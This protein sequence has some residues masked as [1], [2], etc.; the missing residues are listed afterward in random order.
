MRRFCSMTGFLVAWICAGLI[1]CTSAPRDD[2]RGAATSANAPAPLPIS[3]NAAPRNAYVLLS[4]GGT[5]L[6]NNYSQYLQAR[7]IADFFER[8]CANEPTWVFFGAGNRE[9]AAPVLGDTLRE[10]KRDGVIVQSWLPGTLK[11][12]RPATRDSFLRALREE[13]LPTVKS[14]GTLY[15]FVGDHGELIG[16]NDKRE[17]AITLWQLKRGR[18]RGGW[19]TDDR[20]VLGVAELRQILADGIGRGRVVFC[21]TQCHGGGFHQLGVVREQKPLRS[22]FS[23]P[24]AGAVAQI[25]TP[26][27]RAA[28]FTATD[29]QSVAAGCDPDPDP[30]RWAGYERFMPESLLGMDLMN[31]RPK[32]SPAASFA[33]AHEAA[34][35]V[36]QTVD[37]PRAT[38]EHYLA[39]W[40]RLIETQ[41]TN[42]LTIT[43]RTQEAV[44]AFQRAV[45][46]GVVDAADDALRTRRDQFGR[47]TQRLAEQIP[48]A[49][50]LLL[51]GTQ[52]ELE[53]AL[54]ERGGGRGGP[55]DA[56]RASMTELRR[57]WSDTLRPAWKAAVERGAV[58]GLRGAA[59]DFEKQL[60]STE[61]GGRDL[62]LPRGGN[63]T[64]L[65]NEAYWASGYDNPAT[66]NRA[67]AEAIMQWAAERRARIVAWGRMAADAQ[68]RAAAEK[69]GP[70]PTLAAEAPRSLSRRTAAER[71]LF[72]RRV[73]AA[74]QFLLAMDVQPA[75]AE[76]R[77]LIEL[78]HT[79]V[80][81]ARVSQP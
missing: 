10:M 30:D 55:R 3:T 22:W 81:P 67:E 8:E 13:I 18:R 38:S 11:N 65:S 15:L 61:A 35:M 79:P 48:D 40:A 78:E 54:R 77:Q 28:G 58:P 56:R 27:L 21:M 25:A 37:K 6:T 57:V 4:G 46:R 41:L 73:L 2:Q 39:G 36:D 12:N 63:S 59:L 29:Q 76:L 17:S 20:E 33:L 44:A 34:T 9:G 1:G 43:P 51:T 53:A 7:A 52:K 42:T 32:F 49:R 70:G 14:G 31:G 5:P 80:R 16:E 24:P 62:L 75:L 74:W 60:L 71:V 47:F 72:Y 26:G 19:S 23:N 45:D 69:I 68:V 50:Q 66:L 64:A